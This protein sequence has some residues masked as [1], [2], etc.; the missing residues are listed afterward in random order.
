MPPP[1]KRMKPYDADATGRSTGDTVITACVVI[2]LFV[3][4]KMPERITATI[5][6]VREWM[7]IPIT[8]TSIA[9]SARFR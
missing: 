8:S 1:M 5:V 6:T 7:K 3:P 4:M 9:K 2:V